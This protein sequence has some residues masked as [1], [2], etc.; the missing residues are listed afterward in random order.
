MRAQA[1][2][3]WQEPERP[4][5]RDVFVM[6]YSLEM[7]HESAFGVGC[8][9]FHRRKLKMAIL[10]LTFLKGFLTIAASAGR[11]SFFMSFSTH[12]VWKYSARGVV[13]TCQSKSLETFVC[14]ATKEMMTWL[15]SGEAMGEWLLHGGGGVEHLT[16]IFFVISVG[17]N[18][19]GV[20]CRHVLVAEA[21][22]ATHL[23][24]IAV[25]GRT[26]LACLSLGRILHGALFRRVGISGCR[27]AHVN[28]KGR[29]L[30][31]RVCTSTLGLM[32]API[33]SL[34][35]FGRDDL[36]AAG[37][38]TFWVGIDICVKG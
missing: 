37:T 38:T 23:D 29:I 17:P 27:R 34:V 8:I 6:S 33:L 30:Q 12:L 13:D 20:V 7:K 3:S 9:H 26:L 32:G 16:P 28:E 36:G 25:G 24:G 11:P 15:K 19:S 14:C 18:E 10:P 1:E 21:A 2:T 5:L 22:D 31:M 35:P 4:P